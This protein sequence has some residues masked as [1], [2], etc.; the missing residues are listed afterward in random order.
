[1]WIS[2][3]YFYEGFTF[4]VKLVR[5]MHM[6]LRKNRLPT[7]MFEDTFKKGHVFKNDIFL[8]KCVKL[9]NNEQRFGITVSKKISKKAVIRNRLKRQIREIIKTE[10]KNIQTGVHCTIVTQ[11]TIIKLSYKEIEKKLLQVFKHAKII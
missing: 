1:M 9:E 11:P 10:L 3:W 8:L 4:Y 6:L 2:C 7:N 5:Y